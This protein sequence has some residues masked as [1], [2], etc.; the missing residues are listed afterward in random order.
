MMVGGRKKQNKNY[1]LEHAKC[2]QVSIAIH[3]H[4]ISVHQ[5]LQKVARIHTRKDFWV[6]VRKTKQVAQNQNLLNLAKI[7]KCNGGEKW[8]R[9]NCLII[10]KNC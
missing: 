9:W 4:A 2:G 7:F 10:Q 6:L 3:A 5:Q 8:I 1:H